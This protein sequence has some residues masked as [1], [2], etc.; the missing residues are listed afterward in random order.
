MSGMR[1]SIRN[2]D[3]IYLFMS[4]P[5]MV[6]TCALPPRLAAW[7]SLVHRNIAA[8]NDLTTDHEATRKDIAGWLLEENHTL[9]E[10][11][12]QVGMS[13]MFWFFQ[14]RD[15]FMS[16][17]RMKKWSSDGMDDH[18]LLPASPGFVTRADCFFVSHFWQS[19]KHPDPDGQTVPA[20]ASNQ[21]RASG[22]VVHLGRLD[23][24]A[25][26]STI[27]TQRNLFPSLFANHIQHYSQI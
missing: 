15:A 9:D 26:K 13:L 6:S 18:I 10:F 17:K 11:L 27:V 16:Q 2:F 21:A 23:V 22:I 14:R 7:R 3:P 12:A 8:W 24:Y 20:S 1:A 5:S 19:P 25:S 4:I